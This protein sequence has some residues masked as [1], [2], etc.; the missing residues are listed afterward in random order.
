MI[1]INAL[2]QAALLSV[3][4]EIAVAAARRRAFDEGE[5]TDKALWPEIRA[6]ALAGMDSVFEFDLSNASYYFRQFPELGSRPAPRGPIGAGIRRLV[7]ELTLEQMDEEVQ[8]LHA[9]QFEKY[10]SASVK[11]WSAAAMRLIRNHGDPVS[12]TMRDNV[13]AIADDAPISALDGARETLDYVATRMEAHAGYQLPADRTGYGTL[14]R[15]LREAIE[16][17]EIK[18]SLEAEHYRAPV[19]TASAPRA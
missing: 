12:K 7:L 16:F 19:S 5:T 15:R 2:Q 14:A 8:S 11:V 10:D 13:D 17:L 3:D 18:V 1:D 6:A 9:A 4:T